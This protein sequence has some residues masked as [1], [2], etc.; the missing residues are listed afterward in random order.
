[1]EKNFSAIIAILM[2]I[3]CAGPAFGAVPAAER[4][5]LLDLYNTT[6][7]ASWTN[8]SG[9]LGPAGTE[10]SWYGVTCD[11]GESAVIQIDLHS[12]N[13]SGPVPAAIGDLAGLQQLNLDNNQLAGAIPPEIGGL[14]QLRHLSLMGNTLSGAIPPEIG[15]LVNLSSLYLSGNNLTGTIPPETGNLTQLTHLHMEINQLSGSLPAQLGNLVNLVELD[16]RGNQLAGALPPAIGNL[17]LLYSLQLSNNQFSGP[18]PPEIGDLTHLLL[19]T[20]NHNLL[21]G[22]VPAEITNLTGLLS[23]DFRYNALYASNPA[24]NAFLDSKQA[25]GD[26]ESTQT[27]APSASGFAVNAVGDTFVGLTWTPG[28]YTSGTGGYEVY[29]SDT[30]GG[31]YTLFATTA[32][33]TASSSSV[34]GLTPGTTYYFVLRTKTDPYWVNG[35][36]LYSDYTSEVS[37]TTTGTPPLVPDVTVADSAAPDNDHLVGFGTVIAGSSSPPQT[38][39]ISNDGSAVLNVAGIS[40]S[41]A[42]AAEFVLNA[43]D[44]T[45]GTCGSANPAIGAGGSCSVSV[46]FTP[47][48]EGARAAS[49]VIASN[50]PDEPTVTVSLTG[51]GA[52]LPVPDISAAPMSAGF[53]VVLVGASST[54]QEVVISNYGTADLNISGMAVA[55]AHSGDFSF[56]SNGGSNPCLSSIPVVPPNGNCTVTLT[57]RPAASGSRSASLEIASDDPDE[58]VVSITLSGTGQAYIPPVTGG[59]GGGSFQCF[60]A[61]AAYGSHLEPEVIALRQFRD[62]YLLTNS[63]GRAFV[64]FYYRHS[65][66]LAR[67]ITEH[68]HLRTATRAALTPVVFWVKYPVT[69]SSLAVLLA[70]IAFS[71]YKWSTKSRA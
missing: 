63:M 34:T 59:G 26:W 70:G 22:E 9:W 69:A 25:G 38:V 50:D 43:G 6:G 16:V 44:G 13:L 46:A 54:P 36:M 3:I 20:I 48:G 35:T 27:V 53:G 65:P 52:P 21:K 41:G 4:N 66:P 17:T 56:D 23:T 37:A 15:N 61:T 12:N 10:C 64:R 58:P 51:T 47:A 68:E 60:I 14:S 45:G 29:Y 8:S 28:G 33:K 62:K 1:M 57:F 11:A 2:F 67:F 39:T 55:G 7:G 32:D 40:L 19:L 31:P 49:L 5:A 71:I 30:S 18:L 24:V 42:A